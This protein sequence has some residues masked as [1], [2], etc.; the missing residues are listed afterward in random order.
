MAGEHLY[1]HFFGE[2][3]ESLADFRVIILDKTNMNDGILGI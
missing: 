1:A 3:H 2:E